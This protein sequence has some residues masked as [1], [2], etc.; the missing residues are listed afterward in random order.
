[1]APLGSSC[2]QFFSCGQWRMNVK[3]ADQLK[4][5]VFDLFLTTMSSM[6]ASV[7]PWLQARNI[8]VLRPF[9]RTTASRAMGGSTRHI[10]ILCGMLPRLTDDEVASLLPPVIYANLDIARMPS[11]EVLDGLTNMSAQLP[12]IQNLVPIFEWLKMIMAGHL[13]DRLYGAA[14][15][16]WARFWPWVDFILSHEDRVVGYSPED[17]LLFHQSI[18]Q[19]ALALFSNPIT[20][21]L[22]AET[23]GLRRAMVI[24][25]IKIMR[26][27]KS[28]EKSRMRDVAPPI[29]VLSDLEN[30]QHLAEIIDG[31]GG[32]LSVL[33]RIVTETISLAS[34]HPN[35]Q[36]TGGLITPCV[37]LLQ[38]ISMKWPETLAGMMSSKLASALV[39]ALG[40]Q[41]TPPGERPLGIQLC[42]FAL[43]QVLHMPQAHSW[44]IPVLRKGL[45]TQIVFWGEKLGGRAEADTVGKF[46][47]LLRIL[48]AETLVHPSI[49][50][51]MKRCFDALEE[52]ASRPPFA[53]CVLY[54]M[55]AALRDLVNERSAVVE[56][57]KEP[58]IR[59]A[60][61]AKIAERDSFRRC[62]GCHTAVYC[63]EACQRTDWVAVD[64]HRAEC[65]QMLEVYQGLALIGIHH[66]DKSFIRT[67]L[68]MDCRRHRLRICVELVQF[69]AQH[70]QVPC[71]VAF[72]YQNVTGVKIFVLPIQTSLP[73]EM[74][75]PLLLRMNRELRQGFV[76]MPL[77]VLCVRHGKNQGFAPFPVHRFS[78]PL[79]TGLVDIAKALGSGRIPREQVEPMVKNC[80]EAV[81]DSAE[82][83]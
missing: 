56:A 81:G 53:G 27:S 21:Y 59:S 23:T 1:M 78:T 80:I 36:L 75:K 5:G 58:R 17:D 67:L 22:V 31:C 46:N 57:L 8:S 4:S 66:R 11:L 7:H 76:S 12:C 65:E 79:F 52:R 43:M 39:S 40:I 41:V 13:F 83:H 55:W 2:W 82:F 18:S 62:G 25:W 20:R 29:L 44:M 14:P 47:Q 24:S 72:N 50:V 33:S 45:L 30:R 68:D 48:L 69:M 77:H 9:L 15:D 6:T 51:E 74:A 60:L 71:L 32:D 42:L 54:P 73:P 16:L 19:T 64:G 49:V 10:A 28:D 34:K 61:C 38:H 37:L 63:S 70:P 26:L 3:T 35:E